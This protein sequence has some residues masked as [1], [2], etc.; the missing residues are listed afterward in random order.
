MK[1][2][3]KQLAL[4]MAFWYVPSFIFLAIYIG[5]YYNPYRVIFDH[6][7]PISL[8]V[9]SVFL[10]KVCLHQFSLK[11]NFIRSL[12]A[13]LYSTVW[14]SILTYYLLVIIGLRSWGQV[15]TEELITSYAGQL[16]QLF[17]ALGTPFIIPVV[18][19]VLIL[20]LASFCAYFFNSKFFYSK[21]TRFQTISQVIL[22]FFLAVLLSVCLYFVYLYTFVT[23]ITANEPFHLTLYAAKS[24]ASKGVENNL[25]LNT[26]LDNEE[27]HIQNTYQPSQ[28]ANNKNVIVIVVDALRPDHMGVY[29]YKRETTP[30]LNELAKQGV[31]TTVHNVRA[32][33]GA[34]A[35]G[36]SSITSSKYPHQLPGT[37]FTLQQVLKKQGYETQMI[38]GGDHTNFY[39]LRAMYGKVDTYYDGSMAKKFYMNDDTLVTDKVNAL[40]VWNGKPIMFQFHLMSVHRLG[41]RLPNYSVYM[42]QKGYTASING[43]PKIEHTNY[44]DNGVLQVDDVIKSLLTTLNAKNY[45][46]NA[47]VV[48][49]AD[50]GDSLGEH[51]LYSHA[52][53][54]FEELLRIP[55][56]LIDFSKPQPADFDTHKFA[57]QIDIAPSILHALKMHIPINWTGHPIQVPI[58]DNQKISYTPFQQRP[59]AGLYDH[60]QTGVLWK[61]WVNTFTHEEFVFE[62]ITDPSES[63]N[64]SKSIPN[65]YLV[66]WKKWLA[67]H[68]LNRSTPY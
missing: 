17:E 10:L 34:S 20:I 56:L 64:L 54:V 39:N 31:L 11:P 30:Y 7:Y 22:N 45:L 27:L 63:Q 16:P 57:T 19:S 68:L 15:I 38:L 52:N 36:L 40:E 29:G 55:L 14:L 18:L 4:E 67:R 24:N 53:S 3:F 1:T 59:Y 66:R 21:L 51:S 62:L 61:Y 49:T 48:I 37:P 8:I 43:P 5:Q 42:P 58:K 6:L 41:G 44:Y 35:C 33:C 26:D 28:Y 12:V 25:H 32:S 46:K 23:P 65:S 2:V 60:S 13:L 9:A 50:H 47:L